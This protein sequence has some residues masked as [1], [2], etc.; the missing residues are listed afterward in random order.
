MN[1]L[2]L[3]N[4]DVV[5]STYFKISVET[6]SLICVLFIDSSMLFNGASQV[7]LVVKNLFA[8]AGDVRD[9]SS[10]PGLGRSPG[11]GHGN[12]LQFSCLGESHDRG[13]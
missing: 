4:F 7:A 13:A 2:H 1:L 9:V 11:A 8:N 10:I 12:P 3:I 6:S 5:F